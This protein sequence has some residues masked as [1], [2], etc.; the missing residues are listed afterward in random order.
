MNDMEKTIAEWTED[1]TKYGMAAKNR[2]QQ[3]ARATDAEWQPLESV[4][5]IFNGV[6]M[7]R[8]TP[9]AGSEYF[10][11][12]YS[13]E[14]PPALWSVVYVA[15]PFSPQPDEMEPHWI[16]TVAIRFNPKNY[17]A[18]KAMLERGWLHKTEES[19]DNFC[20]YV[21]DKLK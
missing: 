1:F 8:R 11:D 5:N 4:E 3:K 7:V 2:W 16:R 10:L 6:Y 14:D 20:R 17:N 12:T 15:A 18:H 9:N 19:A 21:H 13:V